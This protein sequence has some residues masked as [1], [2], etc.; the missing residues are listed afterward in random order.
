VA[1]AMAQV[2]DTLVTQG[3]T[4]SN[5]VRQTAAAARK[6][7]ITCHAL[8]ERRVEN[9]GDGYETAGNVLLDDMLH[10]EYAFRPNGSDMNA[11]AM[12]LADTLREKGR[13]PYFIS[14]GGSNTIGALGYAHAA[15][16]LVYQADTT[17]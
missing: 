10:L 17:G 7:G 1:D 9:A 3:A 12:A 6:V 14:G 8:L 16:E 13:K 2:A 4:Q 11:E 5:H 15:M